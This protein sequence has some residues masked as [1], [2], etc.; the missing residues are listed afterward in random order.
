[1]T[2]S[3][4]SRGRPFLPDYFRRAMV[5]GI[6]L[7]LPL[8]APAQNVTQYEVKAAMLY[9]FAQFMDRPTNRLAKTNAPLIFG[10]V[11]QDPFG[12]S[13]DAV[14]KGQKIGDRAIRIERHAQPVIPT[15]C[16]LLFVSSSLAGETEKI[17][18]S[19]S[20]NAVLT[21]GETEDFTR[22]GG[23]IR[24]YLE[25]NRV[26]FEINLAAMERSGL[27]LHSQVMKLATR[28]TRDGKDV[29]K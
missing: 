7:L 19:L 13:I 14:L 11:G 23:H 8:V 2:R 3:S 5:W 4:Q 22:Q 26:R 9:R 18:A 1:M 6:L 10:I 25:E 20:T 17:I 28:I 21:V 24:L 15:S 12:D 16:H 29:K 27:K